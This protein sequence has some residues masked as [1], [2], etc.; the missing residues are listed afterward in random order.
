[1]LKNIGLNKIDSIRTIKLCNSLFQSGPSQ[2]IRGHK[3]RIIGYASKNSAQKDHFVS[4]IVVSE[5]NKL[6]IEV[7]NASTIN[8]FK[9]K[10]GRWTASRSK[11]IN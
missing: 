6:L 2:N 3:R 8:E 7:I 9:I 5:W 4:N 1:M 10:Y 11:N